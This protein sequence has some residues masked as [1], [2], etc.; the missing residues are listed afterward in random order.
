MAEEK[1]YI[2]VLI[3]IHGY[4]DFTSKLD[5]I[6]IMHFM[7]SVH[8]VADALISSHGGELVTSM[9]HAIVFVMPGSAMPFLEQQ[10]QEI[11][12]SLDGWLKQT[13]PELSATLL[14]HV[15]RTNNRP[16][17]EPWRERY[18]S[19]LGHLA[20]LTGKGIILSADLENSLAGF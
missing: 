6:A 19:E 3:D 20:T 11:K 4:A 16:D 14:G 2:F 5:S 15:A 10:L 7:A 1:E 17:D 9:G 12:S 8:E 18:G 13:S